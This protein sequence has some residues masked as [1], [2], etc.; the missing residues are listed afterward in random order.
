MSINNNVNYNVTL[1][2]PCFIELHV[3]VIIKK[4]KRSEML[5][6]KIVEYFG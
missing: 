6:M 2:S 5:P 4:V 1:L 3:P